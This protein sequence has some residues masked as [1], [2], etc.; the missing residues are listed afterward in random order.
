M[1]PDDVT[2]RRDE[3][4]RWARGA[5]DDQRV[6]AGSI[7][8][9][10][11]SPQWWEMRELVPA[12]I[13]IDDV[14]EIE[15]CVT[16]LPDP[17]RTAIVCVYVRLEPHDVACAHLRR[18]R[19]HDMP[20]VMAEAVRRIGAWLR[21]RPRRDQCGGGDGEDSAAVHFMTPFWAAGNPSELSSGTPCAPLSGSSGGPRCRCCVCRPGNRSSG[22][23]QAGASLLAYPCL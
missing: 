4:S 16:A 6:R 8:T 2:E 12:P 15:R 11:R 10:Y 23:L 9:R 19:V 18:W 22:L 21:Q 20:K 13:N 3:W 14:Q 7:E 17:Y 5:V 1:Q